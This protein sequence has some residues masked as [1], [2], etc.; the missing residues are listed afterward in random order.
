M[1]RPTEDLSQ[2]EEGEG[3]N[4]AS[5]VSHHA[6]I[7]LVD[8]LKL[9]FDQILKREKESESRIKVFLRYD[10]H[11]DVYEALSKFSRSE[12][13]RLKKIFLISFVKKKIAKK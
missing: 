5:I 7:S 6:Q 9:D 3:A 11:Q 1:Q 10:S 12:L 8:L 13:K 2:N 4:T